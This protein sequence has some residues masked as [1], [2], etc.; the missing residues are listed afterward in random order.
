MAVVGRGRN[1]PRWGDALRSGSLGTAL[2]FLAPALVAVVILRIWPAGL[3]LWQSLHEPAAAPGFANLGFG[4]YTYLLSDPVFIESL[5]TTFLFLIIVNPVQIGLAL[6]LALAMDKALPAAGLWRT[7][8]LLPVAVPQSV[9]AIILGVAFRPDG[10]VNAL[11]ATIGIPPQGFMTSTNQALITI[12]MIVSWVG[13]GYWMT[14]LLAGLRDIPPIL[15]EAAEIDGANGWQRFWHVTLPQLRRTLT[16]V[17]VANT[18]ANFLVFAPVQILTKGGPQGSTNL[19]MNEIYTRGFLSGD[20]SGAA[21]ATVILVALV[22]VVVG[23]QFRMMTERA[24][25]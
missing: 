8:M 24:K 6:L 17:L 25:S 19:I 14:F 7:L 11:L 16:F 9:S 13:V 5:T 3:A 21:A 23:I 1:G 12:I 10:P 22:I 2:L 4:N 18:V 15:Y 20:M